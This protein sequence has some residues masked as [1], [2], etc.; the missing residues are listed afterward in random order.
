[1]FYKAKI[2]PVCSKCERVESCEWVNKMTHV[3]DKLKEINA[4]F[5]DSPISVKSYCKNFWVK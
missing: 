4:I 1:M 2:D 5:E 3:Q